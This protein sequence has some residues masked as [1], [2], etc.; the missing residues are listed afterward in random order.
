MTREPAPG[1]RDEIRR[2]W[3]EDARVYDEAPNHALSD[4]VEAAAWRA[5]LLRL[6]PAPPALVLD[7]GAGTG[8]IS[9]LLAELGYRV[10]A[11]D[12]SE[13]MLEKARRKAEERGLRIEFVTGPVEEPP[14]GPFGAVVERHVLWTTLDPKAVLVAWRSA[15]PGGRLLLLEGLWGRDSVVDRARVM[16]AERIRVARGHEHHGHHGEYD[17]AVLEQLPLA[18][19]HSVRPLLRFVATAGW[20]R[21]RLER[22]RD[23]EWAR[24]M[25]TGQ[26]LGALQSVPQFAVIA[27]DPQ[28]P[29]SALG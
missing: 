19:Q 2:W 4:P 24:Q 29:S 22:L 1:V 23:I 14:A 9:L 3:D 8:A 13:K 10:T 17:P 6:L 5:A 18:R 15:A 11:L 26:L 28:E 25:A 21:I 7:A 20:G 16:L 27:D 12:L